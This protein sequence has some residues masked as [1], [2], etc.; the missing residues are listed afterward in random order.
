M[1]QFGVEQAHLRNSTC[2][3]VHIACRGIAE[4]WTLADVSGPRGYRSSGDLRDQLKSVAALRDPFQRLEGFGV[5]D[6]DFPPR[7]FTE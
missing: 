2:G 4:V 6:L 1:V 3:D 5:E 7:H